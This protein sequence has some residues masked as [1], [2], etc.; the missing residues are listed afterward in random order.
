[1][2]VDRTPEQ[3]SAELA[4]LDTAIARRENGEEHVEEVQQTEGE[5]PAIEREAQ[6]HGWLPKEK[7]KG[8]PTKWKPAS[9]YIE[10]GL[11]F[12]SQIKRQ[13]SRL[14][15]Q[16]AELERTGQAFAKYH[17]EAMA[18]KE[19]EIQDAITEAR[20]AARVAV[21]EG[22]DGLAETLETRIELLQEEKAGLKQ[23]RQE[24]ATQKPTVTNNAVTPEGQ[25]NVANALVSDWIE[26]GN[27]WFRDNDQ[28]RAH[29]VEVGRQMVQEGETARGRKLLDLVGQR[30]RDDFPRQFKKADPAPRRNDQVNGG[31]SGSAS[32]AHSV[33]DLPPEDQRLMREFIEK[34][35][36]TKEK[37]LANYFSDSKKVHRSK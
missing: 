16:Y 36:T 20:R 26:D 15:T 25:A 24:S 6:R 17:E 11:R 19:Q 35:W 12:N 2:T 5:D 1:M 28:L 37:F 27:E 31:A 18:R 4:E 32:A 23:Q 22:D 30:V 9:E 29:A 33:H 13:L 3:I 7:Y 21:R 10:N 34:G 14:E 8:D